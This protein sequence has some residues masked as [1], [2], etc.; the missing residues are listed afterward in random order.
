MA[1]AR[2]GGW[3]W[4]RNPVPALLYSRQS[5][6]GGASFSRVRDRCD[7]EGWCGWDHLRPDLS[8][9]RDHAGTRE[10]PKPFFRQTTTILISKAPHQSPKSI[11]PLRWLFDQS[12]SASCPLRGRS[13]VSSRCPPTKIPS[14]YS[15]PTPGLVASELKR[16]Q[17]SHRKHEY[18]DPPVLILLQEAGGCADPTAA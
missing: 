6:I 15:N 13:R 7:F 9:T 11:I 3:A 10:G 16:G 2:R 4:R 5:A 14:L 8:T 18:H 17:L 1:W 12:L